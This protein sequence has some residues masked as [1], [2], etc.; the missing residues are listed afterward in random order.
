MT[1]AH[2]VTKSCILFDQQPVCLTCSP[3]HSPNTVYT[4]N[5]HINLVSGCWSDAGEKGGQVSGGQKQRIAIARALIRRP[6]I[7][8]LDSATS[9]LDTKNECQVG[10]TYCHPLN[11]PHPTFYLSPGCLIEPPAL[12]HQVNQALLNQTNDCTVLLISR[13]MSVVEKADHIV[14]LGDGTVKEQGR[15]EELLAK[16]G[17]YCELVKSDNKSFHRDQQ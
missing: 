15:H 3:T 14:V 6:K 10:G 4:V 1:C 2:I 13:N 16:N 11:P 17:L 7:L 9:E 5:Q 12:S 8:I